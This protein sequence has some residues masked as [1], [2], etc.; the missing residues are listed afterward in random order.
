LVFFVPAPMSVETGTPSSREI[1]RQLIPSARILIA[2]SRRK[3]LFGLPIDF[4]LILSKNDI[5]AKVYLFRR[6]E[7]YAVFGQYYLPEDCVERE[8]PNYDVYR[9]WVERGLLTLTP[10]NVIDFEFIERD[11]IQDRDTYGVLEV[12]FDPSQ[13]TE[14]S[15]RMQSEGL[16]MVDIPQNMSRFNEPMK[17]VAA[18]I[19]AGRIVHDDNPILDWVIGNVG[20][21]QDAQERVF[22][23]KSRPE[24]KI[25]G[26]VALIMA[27]GRY[28][29]AESQSVSYTGVRTV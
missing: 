9:G 26:A 8:R 4:P 27:I 16:T 18:R 1:L 29:V 20:A 6:K 14:L 7:K 12:A 5:A 2:S 21:K 3:I 17:D 22:P 24:N 15:T 23:I 13:A 28:N 10:G 25:D 19:I 11:L